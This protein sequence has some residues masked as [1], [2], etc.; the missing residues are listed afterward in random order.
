M[1]IR[2]TA[3]VPD[4]APPVA[5]YLADCP[6]AVREG[7]LGLRTLVYQVAAEDQRVGPLQETLKWGEP[8]YLTEV[9]RSG[10]TLRL[11]VKK[12][13]PATYGLFFNCRTRLA[14]RITDFYPDTFMLDGTRGLLFSAGRNIP[15][16][17]VKACISLVLTYRLGGLF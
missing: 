17:E 10:T 6:P 2:T 11:A 7:L 12:S 4:P 15:D 14:E 5:A 9:T 13:M 1:D 16:E 8:S 3:R